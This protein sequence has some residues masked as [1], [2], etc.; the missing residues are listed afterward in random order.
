MGDQNDKDNNVVPFSPLDIFDAA[1]LI[2]FIITRSTFITYSR[3]VINFIT[4]S[5][6]AR[7]PASTYTLAISLTPPT[8]TP[9]ASPTLLYIPR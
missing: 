5:L 6:A 9:I 3:F 1:P 2:Y 7:S 4:P 8:R